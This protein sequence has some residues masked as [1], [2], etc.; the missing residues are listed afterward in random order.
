MTDRPQQNGETSQG[1]FERPGNVRK[2]M[3]ALYIGCAASVLLEIT[4]R[5]GHVGH[6]EKM[7]GLYALVGLIG[8]FVLVFVARDILARLVHRREDFYDD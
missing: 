3:W 6:F 8:G 2:L 1:W 5:V 4:L 7:T